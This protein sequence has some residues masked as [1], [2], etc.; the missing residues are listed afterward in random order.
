MIFC[1]KKTRRIRNAGKFTQWD[2][3][4]AACDQKEQTVRCFYTFNPQGL[5][6][7]V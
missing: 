1:R 2:G 4:A 7:F 6:V 5:L 3:L